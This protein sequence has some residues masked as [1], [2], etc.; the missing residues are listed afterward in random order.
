M[1][2]SARQKI[3]LTRNLESL[4][5]LRRLGLLKKDHHGERYD[6]MFSSMAIP[7][8][9]GE[10]K[11][12][13]KVW[14]DE[15]AEIR[16]PVDELCIQCRDAKGKPLGYTVAGTCP[17]CKGKLW[18]SNGKHAQLFIL[19]GEVDDP[20]TLDPAIYQAPMSPLHSKSKEAEEALTSDAS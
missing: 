2:E 14:A 12:L 6:T 7:F 9:V 11:W 4:A 19:V 8:W 18:I 15:L 13:P 1:S 3:R 20:L 16:M 10:E 17:A 5:K